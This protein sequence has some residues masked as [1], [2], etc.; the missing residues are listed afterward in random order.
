MMKKLFFIFSISLLTFLNF[1]SSFSHPLLNINVDDD[2]IYDNIQASKYSNKQVFSIKPLPYI[3]SILA[4]SRLNLI[5]NSIERPIKYIK[6]INTI[7]VKTFYTNAN[8]LLLEGQ[9]GLLL[10]KGFNLITL[11]DGQISLGENF[12]FYYQLRQIFN[13]DTK[14]GE[15]LRTY[16]KFLFGKFSFEA[17]IDN[18]N[19]GNGEYGILLSNNAYPFPLIKLQTEKPLNFVGKWSF[20]ILNGWLF[21]DRQDVSNPMLLGI[22]I[23]YKPFD[24]LEIGG[25][26]TTMYGGD[27]RPKYKLTEYWQLLTSY[28]DNIPGDKYDNDSYAGYDIVVYIPNKWTDT[29]KIYFEQYGTDIYAFWQKEDEGFG[30]K[31]PFIFTLLSRAYNIGIFASK[32][33]NILRLEYVEIPSVFYYHHWY[34]HEGYSYK[35]ISLG[36]PY[37]RNVKVYFF[38][39]HRWINNKNWFT[40]KTAYFK[41]LWERENPEVDNYFVSFEYN[42]LINKTLQISPFFRIDYREKFDTNLLPTKFEFN[43]E[44]K[45]FIT[46]G[47]SIFLRF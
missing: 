45:T 6:P 16:G 12:I 28:R 1:K 15:V 11:E 46:L 37:G 5:A 33:K 8:Y 27:G 14:K 9:S 38:K 30:S 44:S 35:G 32:N 21:E 26:K 18:V 23:V 41:Q 39:F 2:F 20:S 43:D 24:F 7:Q 22:R 13:D 25:T 3:A 19:W 29:L 34:P 42:K 17:G 36:Y 10:K 4:K 31:F 40:L 47:L